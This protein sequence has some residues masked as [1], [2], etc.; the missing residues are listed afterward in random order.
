MP[1]SKETLDE[2]ALSEAEYQLIVKRLGREPNDVEL[3]MFGALWSEHCGYKHSKAL[4]KQ[5]PSRNKRMLVKPGEENAGVVDIGDGLVVVMKI[6]SHNHPSAIEPYQGAATGVGGI[7]RDIFTMGARPIALLNSLRFGPLSDP[8]NRYLFVGVVSGIAGYGNCL[9]IPDVGGEIFFAKC[10]TTN[11]LVNALCLGITRSKSLVR[12][13]AHGKGNLL[14]LV[15][16]DTGR[17]GLHGASGLASKAF[18]EER[19][20]RSAVQVGNPFLEKLLIEACLELAETDWITGM[21]DLGAAGLTSSAVESAARGGSGIE[22]DVLKVPRREKGMTPYEVVLSESQER[23]LVMVKK[24]HQ[25]KVKALF[26]RWELDSQIVGEV[27]DDGLARIKEG[28]KVVAEVPVSLLTSPPVYRRRV[29]KPE[30]LKQLQ[31]FD[32]LSV[33]DLSPRKAGA[34][35]LQLLAS[36]NIASKHC[37]YRQYDHQVGNDTVVPP[38]S[39]AAVLR[40]KETKKA[41]ALTTDGNARYCYVNP[42][43]GGV[44]AVAEAARNLVCSGA[45]PLA[46]TDC[47]NFGNPEKD[48]VYYQLKECINGMTRACQKLRVP[49][50]SGNVS[51]YNETTGKDIYPTPVVGMVGLIDDVARH[52]TSGF[53]S[54]GDLVFL[55]GEIRTINSSIGSSEYLELIHGI[56]GGNPY[57]D[58]ELERRLHRCC[59]EAVKRGLVNSAHDCS[60]G[61]LAVALAESCLVNHLGFISDDWKIEARLDATL[62]GEAQARIIVSLPPRAAWKLQRLAARWQVGAKRLGTVGG[63]RLTIEGC[64][65]LPLEELREA[66]WYGLEKCL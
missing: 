39:D 8:H 16:A 31:T 62:F 64:I 19:E 48:D 33:P 63:T 21:Q 30:W 56:I 41:I 47:L 3:G 65:D 35:L 52:C 40:I 6:E 57:V 9:G 24:E 53:K 20:L 51:L 58:L 50:I 43:L 46:I 17:D 12:A 37:V 11:P 27:T 1:V 36:P 28:E 49:V 10:Y 15:G 14:M 2:I 13:K 55:L 60:E 66:W 5:L 32:I 18:Q 38:G 22:I 7:V 29:K 34:T 23:M 59:L 44:I 45:Q 61:G 4:L 42:Y 26:A 25:D 54:E